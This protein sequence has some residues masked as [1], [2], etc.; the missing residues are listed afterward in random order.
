MVWPVTN[1]CLP[2][3][4]ADVMHPPQPTTIFSSAAQELVTDVCLRK[5]GESPRA[6][7]GESQKQRPYSDIQRLD[8][9][10]SSRRVS[11]LLK[12]IV[13]DPRNHHYQQRG[14]GAVREAEGLRWSERVLAK[15]AT[16]AVPHLYGVDSQEELLLMEYVAGKT[17]D[18]DLSVVRYLSAVQNRR[19]VQREFRQLGR[20]LRLF[21]AD[22]RWE[23]DSHELLDRWLD[24]TLERLS[25]IHLL[26]V[27]GDVRDAIPVHA[28]KQV[29][30]RLQSMRKQLENT[31]LPIAA[32]HGDFGPWNVLVDGERLVVIDLFGFRQ[33][34][35]LIDL[36]CLETYLETLESS[37]TFSRY[38]LRQFRGAFREGY[39]SPVVSETS[40]LFEFC[41]ACQRVCRLHDEVSRGGAGWFVRL[42]QRQSL[43]RLLALLLPAA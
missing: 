13:H 14:H 12:R 34:L 6:I 21:Q 29:A 7:R 37:W 32:C 24:V 20:W 1:V 42:R 39:G 4:A 26:D 23:N 16:L 28:F 40:I 36:L 17:L 22:L 35:P 18:D 9:D 10:L 19:R 33:D 41:L 3:N 27:P 43:A 38:W 2:S 15:E 11:L 8:L 30:E 25:G 5:W 31:P